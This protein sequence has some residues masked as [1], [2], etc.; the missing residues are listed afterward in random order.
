SVW[1]ISASGTSAPA[2]STH[3]ANVDAHDA[4]RFSDLAET[5]SVVTGELEAFVGTGAGSGPCSI[6]TC[7]F[8]P[9]NP[10]DDTAARRGPSES[11]HDVRSVG[12]NS[13][14]GDGSIAGFHCE[15]LRFGGICL[16]CT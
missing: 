15:K 14:V 11:G 10:N 9:P 8:V 13:R 2:P 3:S 4:I 12:T 16:R 6:T 7:A 5:T 1:A